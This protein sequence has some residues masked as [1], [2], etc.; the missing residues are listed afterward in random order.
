M[1]KVMCGLCDT[2]YD[3]DN[4]EEYLIHIHPEPQSGPYRKAWLDSKM[5]YEDWVKN[6]SEGKAWGFLHRVENLGGKEK[7]ITN[8]EIVFPTMEDM[9]GKD[10]KLY[11]RRGMNEHSV[12]EAKVLSIDPNYNFILILRKDIE[13]VRCVNWLNLKNVLSISVLG[14]R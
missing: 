13:D 14:S 2:I 8:E 4:K 11:V 12:I 6:T 7:L 3:A 9:I 10:V 5:S 1:N